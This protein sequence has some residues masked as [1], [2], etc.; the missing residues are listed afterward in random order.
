[1]LL[2]ERAA[3]D[4]RRAVEALLVAATLP[5]GGAREGFETGGR[6]V[7]FATDRSWWRLS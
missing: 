7:A 5:L 6:V 3:P 4:D 2:I 1:M